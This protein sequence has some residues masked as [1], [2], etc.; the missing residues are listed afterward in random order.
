MDILVTALA[1]WIAANSNLELPDPPQISFVP[2]NRLV[3]IFSDAGGKNP[4]LHLE[5]FYHPEESTIYLPD[6]WR[7]S[8]Q[9]DKSILLHE[10]VHHAQWH[11][12]AVSSC[13]G[14]MERQAYHLQITW[15]REHGVQAP[16]E[17]IGT[18]A[19]TV[20]LIGSC[21]E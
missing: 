19:M 6:S 5:A 9:R 15:L 8:E 18:N 16:Y 1:S 2:R 17:L 3:E 14:S 10:L 4:F 13:P 7:R 11:N 21:E 12:E 20:L